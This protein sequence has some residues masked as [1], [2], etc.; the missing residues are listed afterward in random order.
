MIQNPDH[1]GRVDVGAAPRSIVLSTIAL[2]FAATV[3]L[4]ASATHPHATAREINASSY[5][6]ADSL[7]PNTGLER[8][9]ALSPFSGVETHGC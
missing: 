6:C 1:L 3:A 7:L 4:A 9:Q 8:L 5:D 2:A